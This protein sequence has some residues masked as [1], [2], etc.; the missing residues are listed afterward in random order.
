MLGM[1][2]NSTLVIGYYHGLIL[3][4]IDADQLIE[5]MLSTDLLT[6]H[7]QNYILSGH[8]L[9]HRNWLLLEHV[10]HLDSQSLLVFSELVQDMWPQI[11]LQLI[12]GSYS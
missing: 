6:A 7:E 5:E 4:G 10:R 8:S 11:G 9:H 3:R 1:I 2:S 12:A